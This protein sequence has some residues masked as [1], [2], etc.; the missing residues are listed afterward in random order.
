MSWYAYCLTEHPT[1]ANGVRARRPFVLD[2]IQG[3]NS[4]PVMSYPSGEFAVI[5]S[6]YDRATSKLDEKSVL[7]HARVVSQ[8]FRTATVLPFRFGTI[9]DT[10]DAIRQAVRSNRRTFC[11][12]VARLRGKS[13]MRIKLTVRDGSLRGPLDEIVLPDTVGREYLTKLREK[14]SRERER[15]TKARALSVQVHKLFNPLEEEVSCKRVDSDGM[16][17]DIAHLIDTKS[18]EKYQN[19]YSTAAKQLKNCQ[20]VVTGPWPPYHFLPGK[21]RTV[22]VI[23]CSWRTPSAEGVLL[24]GRPHQRPAAK[25]QD[26]A[27]CRVQR[28]GSQPGEWGKDSR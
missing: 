3:V 11:E 22:P 5:V 7:E 2:G 9:F 1:L 27:A 20:M 16:L 28:D 10:E 26:S 4:A 12:S 6:E 19:R 23:T 25:V 24:W 8:S 15:Q 14:A 21:V 17:L 13:E 18:I